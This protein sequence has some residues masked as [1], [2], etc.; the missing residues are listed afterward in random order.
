MIP[1]FTENSFLSMEVIII[2]LIKIVLSY[3]F[4]YNTVILDFVLSIVSYCLSPERGAFSLLLLRY[5]LIFGSC[6][7][8][9]AIVGVRKKKSVLIQAALLTL[10]NLAY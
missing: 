6:E 8:D 9:L 10:E 4:Y 7:F 1:L 3:I 2:I 5:L